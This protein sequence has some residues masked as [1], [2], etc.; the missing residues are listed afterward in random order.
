MP[1]EANIIALLE[2]GH[3]PYFNP[4]RHDKRIKIN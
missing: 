2:A 4:G 3:I 1:V